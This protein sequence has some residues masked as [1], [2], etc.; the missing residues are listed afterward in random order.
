[1]LNRIVWNGTVL[2]FEIVLKLNKLFEIEL[3]LIK[4]N[5]T[6]IKLNCLNKDYLTKLNSLKYKC[7]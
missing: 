7:V 2:D 1:M 6:Y 3:F 4:K 5:F